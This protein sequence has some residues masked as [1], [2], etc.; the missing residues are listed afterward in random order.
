MVD[1][2]VA[3]LHHPV[4]QLGTTYVSTDTYWHVTHMVKCMVVLYI[5]YVWGF[6][7]GMFYCMAVPVTLYIPVQ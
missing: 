1:G 6:D 2:C 5:L 4:W 7:A 3:I